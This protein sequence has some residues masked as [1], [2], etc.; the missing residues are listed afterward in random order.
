MPRAIGYTK[1]RSARSYAA[2]R[3]AKYARCSVPEAA[4]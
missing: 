1:L 3:S 2:A 4:M